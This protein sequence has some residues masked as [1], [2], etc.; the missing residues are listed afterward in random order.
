MDCWKIGTYNVAVSFT[1]FVCWFKYLVFLFYTLSAWF[2]YCRLLVFV[3]ILFSWKEFIDTSLWL[4]NAKPCRNHALL[5]FLNPKIKLCYTA[6]LQRLQPDLHVVFITPDQR[7]ATL[8]L[9]RM[10]NTYAVFC[11]DLPSRL[12]VA[13]NELDT[14]SLSKVRLA[15][16]L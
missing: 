4:E 5:W 2:H 13:P 15:T 6:S 10:L 12:T 7:S 16:K 1:I 11:V 8:S 14:L 3:G 9:S